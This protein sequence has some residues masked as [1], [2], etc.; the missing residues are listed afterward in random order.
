MHLLNGMQDVKRVKVSYITLPLFKEMSY[1]RASKEMHGI[2]KL[3]GCSWR[4]I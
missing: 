4:L 1:P 3:L 2:H